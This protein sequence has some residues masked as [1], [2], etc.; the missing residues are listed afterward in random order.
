[1]T[2]DRA[3][4][5]L[6]ILIV[7]DSHHFL[8]AACEVLEHGGLTVVGTASTIAEALRVA[9]HLTPDAILVDVDLGEESGFDL[10]QRLAAVDSTP[11]VLISTYAESDL[12]EL[13]ATSPAV[14]FVTKSEFSASAISNL[15]GNERGLD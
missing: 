2:V 3:P 6:R 5:A 9:Q 8:H 12:A 15:L 10:A 13:I 11:V 7:D 4:T 14:G 1:M